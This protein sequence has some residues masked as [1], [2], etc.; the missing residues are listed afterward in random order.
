VAVLLVL[1]IGT[2]LGGVLGAFLAV[3]TASVLLAINEY[4]RQKR[5]KAFFMPAENGSRAS[6][7]TA[8]MPGPVRE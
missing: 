5:R 1:S 3:P 7:P 4:Y 2:V 6:T 8:P